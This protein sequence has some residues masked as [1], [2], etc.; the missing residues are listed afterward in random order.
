M[1]DEITV[2]CLIDKTSYE[3]PVCITG[4]WVERGNIRAVVYDI[5]RMYM[6]DGPFRRYTLNNATDSVLR[7]KRWMHARFL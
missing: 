1:D 6:Y 5:L 7:R 2:E 3:K 4:K